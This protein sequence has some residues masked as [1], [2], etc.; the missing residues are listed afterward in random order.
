M[1][2]GDL[3]EV[4]GSANG[5]GLRIRTPGQFSM[6]V[7]IRILE[8][9]DRHPEVYAK[10]TGWKNGFGLEVAAWIPIQAPNVEAELMTDGDET[11]IRRVSG[12][13]E[14]FERLLDLARDLIDTHDHRELVE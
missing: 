2:A 5:A 10:N 9:F 1:A 8:R 3:I 13:F 11:F 14:D 7:A 12:S 4:S 6:G